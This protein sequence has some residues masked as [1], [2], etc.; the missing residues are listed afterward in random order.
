MRKPALSVP[1]SKYE[2]VFS[3]FLLKNFYILG[4]GLKSLNFKHE[5]ISKIRVNIKN[6]IDGNGKKRLLREINRM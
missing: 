3:K 5:L 2:L 1:Q 4:V 6:V